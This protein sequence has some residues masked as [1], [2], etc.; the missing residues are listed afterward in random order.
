MEDLV[1]V[2]SN[3]PPND[4]FWARLTEAVENGYLDWVLI[5]LP[6]EEGLSDEESSGRVL[7]RG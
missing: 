6:R 5:A 7:F 4:A 3:G 2:F 1:W